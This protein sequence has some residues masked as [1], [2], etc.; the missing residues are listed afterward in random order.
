[1]HAVVTNGTRLSPEWLDF[2]ARNKFG[3]TV[4]LDGPAALHID[5]ASTRQVARHTLG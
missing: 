1:M 2:L 3:V 5:S 4:S